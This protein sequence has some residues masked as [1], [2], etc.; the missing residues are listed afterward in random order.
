M[1][2]QEGERFKPEFEGYARA[3]AA[4]DSGAAASV[5]PEQLLGGRSVL[6]SEGSRK[7]VRYLA[8]DGEGVPNLGEARLG[9]FTKE[10]RRCQV[11]FQVAEAK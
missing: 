11:A 10:Q 3:Q 1:P 9:F 2:L 7:G 5:F 8:A 6:Q 4:V